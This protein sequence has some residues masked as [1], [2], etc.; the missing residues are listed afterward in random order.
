MVSDFAL[1]TAAYVPEQPRPQRGTLYRVRYHDHTTYL[2]GTIH[3]GRIEFFPL[4][5][6]A[7]QALADASTL[8]LEIDL[9]DTAALQ[10]AAIKYGVYADGDTLDKHI[11]AATLDRLQKALDQAGLSYT[12]VSHMKAWMAGN[13]L[14]IA[15]LEHQGYDTNLATDSYLS[16]A[17]SRQHKNII[18]L[19]TADFQLSLF[20][21]MTEKQQEQYLNDNLDDIASGAMREKTQELIDAWA[22]A[23]EKV[24]KEL[25]IEA[26]YDQTTSGKFFLQELLNKRNPEMANKVEKML[27]DEKS[28]FVAIGLMHLI[29]ANGVPQLLAKRGYEVTKLY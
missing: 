20:D 1:T 9:L 7:T 27:K 22:K 2:F 24:F 21:G 13:A 10:Q 8:A 3:V 6:Q 29:G 5:P 18:G 17:A 15:V 14:L 11:S 4:E 25:L 23:D 28:T 19:E 16:A 12:M 26:E